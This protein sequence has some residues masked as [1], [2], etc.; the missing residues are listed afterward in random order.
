MEMKKYTQYRLTKFVIE[1][2]EEFS[3]WEEIT[4]WQGKSLIGS[5]SLL[6]LLKE[7]KK[8]FKMVLLK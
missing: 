8:F 1:A 2:K 3:D 4:S 6:G 7:I 5:N